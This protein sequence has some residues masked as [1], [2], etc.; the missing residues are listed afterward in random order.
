MRPTTTDAAFY[1][2]FDSHRGWPV[3]AEW[4]MELYNYLVCGFSPGSFHTALFANDLYKAAASSHHL[5]TWSAIM[6]MCK[7]ITNVAPYGSFGSYENVNAWLDLSKDE[8]RVR[9]ENKGLLF[10]EEDVMWNVLKA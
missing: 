3:A 8:R 6:A 5:N 1:K 2:T 9:L 10:K 7:W 4:Q